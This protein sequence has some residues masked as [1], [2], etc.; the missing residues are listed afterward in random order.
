MKWLGDC[1]GLVIG[2]IQCLVMVS[3]R[4]G[5]VKG[6][7]V[8]RLGDW[9][10]IYMMSL[11]I[12]NTVIKNLSLLWGH[13]SYSWPSSYWSWYLGLSPL[14]NFL[15]SSY[16][17][18]L[19]S[20]RMLLIFLTFLILIMI[21]GIVSIQLDFVKGFQKYIIHVIFDINND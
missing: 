19:Y 2:D 14:S 5:L 17:E 11:V 15:K 13:P 12:I 8:T 16:Q 7:R 6:G 9:R 10:Y 4:R 20:W 18:P 1:R 3:D 21:L